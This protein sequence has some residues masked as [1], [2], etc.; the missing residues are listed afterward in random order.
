MPRDVGRIEPFE[1]HNAGAWKAGDGSFHLSNISFEFRNNGARLLGAPCRS[2]Y[3]ANIRAHIRKRMWIKSDD[4]WLARPRLPRKMRQRRAQI[5]RC[6]CADVAK[7]LRDDQIRLDRRERGQINAVQAFAAFK[8]FA[9]LA[10]D[11]C[12]ALRV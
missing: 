10:V 5:V 12:G 4:L 3:S 2:T 11:G 1:A 6:G 7:V 8:E 9:N